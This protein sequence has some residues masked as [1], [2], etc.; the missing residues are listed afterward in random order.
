MAI[1]HTAYSMEPLQ[2]S[3]QFTWGHC[4]EDEPDC[5]TR[6]V[7][8]DIVVILKGQVI[9]LDESSPVLAVLIVD[10]G[11]VIWELMEFT[12][13]PNMLLLLTMVPSRLVLKIISSA[14]KTAEALLWKLI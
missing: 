4:P 1:L 3:S 11:R 9:L 2:W 5:E 12:Y 10:G 14:M 13:N 6:P 8:G 7:K